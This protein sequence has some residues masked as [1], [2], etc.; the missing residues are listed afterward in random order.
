MTRSLARARSLVLALVAVLALAACDNAA[1]PPAAEVNGDV[2]SNEQLARDV[3]LFRFLAALQ[4]SQ[5]GQAAEGETPESA[6]ARY[7]LSSL[8]QEDLVKQY[9]QANGVSVAEDSVTQ[10][11]GQVEGSLGGAGTLDEQL[12]TE[13]MT[14]ADLQELVRRLLLFGQVQTAV[15]NEQLTDPALRQLYEQN[16]PA[17][18]TVEVAHILVPTKAEAEDIAAQATPDTFADLAKRYSQDPGS[19]SNGGSLG[20]MVEDAFRS[21]LDPTFAE[22][23]LALRPGQISA[24]VQ[25]QF[26]WHV[27]EM[28]SRTVEPFESVKDQIVS[29]ASGQ[30]FSDWLQQQLVAA[31]ISVNPRYGVLDVANGQVE[32]VRSTNTE[33]GFVIPSASLSPSPAP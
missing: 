33:S 18:T 19:A 1:R 32:P 5:C 22:A 7:T 9:A 13:E 15:A 4:Q 12:K 26:G 27:I 8:I 2:V 6:C 28:V 11:I 14:R 23:A 10:T 21:Q 16:L 24:P 17:Y 29:D 30:V 25:T 20:V 3:H 31:D